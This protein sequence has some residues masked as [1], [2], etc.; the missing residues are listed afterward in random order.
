M[1]ESLPTYQFVTYY[2]ILVP[3][4]GYD[5]IKNQESMYLRTCANGIP[6]VYNID[7][8]T[9]IATITTSFPDI[10]RSKFILLIKQRFSSLLPHDQD[11]NIL[12][13]Q[14][15]IDIGG[16]YPNKDNFKEIIL[17]I[18]QLY[19]LMIQVPLQ[20]TILFNVTSMQQIATYP[21]IK[22][23]E[24]ICWQERAQLVI[25]TFT[26][27]P[28]TLTSTFFQEAALSLGSVWGTART[29]TMLSPEQWLLLVNLS[30]KKCCS[31]KLL[32]ELANQPFLTVVSNVC[33]IPADPAI[34]NLLYLPQYHLLYIIISK[35]YCN[36]Y[37]NEQIQGVI[38]EL[39]SGTTDVV[40]STV[41]VYTLFVLT[42]LIP[43]ECCFQS[44]C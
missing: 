37:A 43:R 4:D 39:T 31:N 6:F 44:K 33:S 21:I 1:C 15:L 24:P 25:D 13:T 30:N 16:M 40:N 36:S 27:L 28:S 23:C 29:M 2:N 34:G 42:T 38:D 26:D 18:E 11:A 41:Y 9:R 7:I 3:S 17:R 14:I 12:L 22:Q 10:N 32:K 20:T 5:I 35:Y 19:Q 8:P